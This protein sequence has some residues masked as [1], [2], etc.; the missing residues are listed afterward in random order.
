VRGFKKY[1]LGKHIPKKKKFNPKNAVLFRCNSVQ[2]V[3]VMQVVQVET[4]EIVMQVV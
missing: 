3:Q 2:V 1:I 4:G